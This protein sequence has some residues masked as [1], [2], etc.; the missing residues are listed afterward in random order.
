M[1]NDEKEGGPNSSDHLRLKYKHADEIHLYLIR[2]SGHI[3]ESAMQSQA[4]NFPFRPISR[5]FYG[6]HRPWTRRRTLLLVLATHLVQGLIGA[7]GTSNSRVEAAFLAAEA[8]LAKTN[9]VVHRWHLGRAAFDLAE[10]TSRDKEKARL[11]EI[12]RAACRAALVESPASAP[13]HYY[14]ALCLG[15]LAQTKSVG[16]LRLI[17]EIQSEFETARVLDETFDYAGSDR[18]LGLLYLEAPSWPTSVGD[19]KKARQH[20][21]RAF[22]LAPEYPDNRLSLLE[23]LVRVKDYR[24]AVAQFGALEAMWAKAKTQFTGEE[25]DAAWREWEHHKVS[26]AAKIEKLAKGTKTLMNS[27]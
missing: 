5:L 25:W 9:S 15:E 23:L 12:G 16:A 20:L 26:L 6:R 19:R 22:F 18:G 8:A 27:R 21:E 24:A 17:H 7:D 10:V 3:I 13:A 4:K 14:L 1:G 11:A 2:T